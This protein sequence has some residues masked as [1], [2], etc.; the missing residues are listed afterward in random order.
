ML[1]V[2]FTRTTSSLTTSPATAVGT[3]EVDPDVAA[4]PAPA[5]PV[6]EPAPALPANVAAATA[7][8]VEN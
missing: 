4:E 7:I 3:T 6:A 1:V 8:E 5:A 2:L